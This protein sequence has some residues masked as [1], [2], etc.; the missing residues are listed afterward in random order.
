M[1]DTILFDPADQLL[2]ISG[3]RAQISPKAFSVLDYLHQHKQKLVTKEDLLSAVWP[4]VFVTDAVL[5]VAVGELRKALNDH[6]K[7]PTFIETVHRRGYRF[8]GDFTLP[9]D[10]PSAQLTPVVNTQTSSKSVLF[11]YFTYPESY[12]TCRGSAF[13]ISLVLVLIPPHMFGD[14]MLPA[15]EYYPR[16]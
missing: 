11:C 16:S 2:T 10:V 6:P 7:Q 5:K 14:A 8:I 12:S 13:F 3:V 4:T 9:D 15:L 1:S